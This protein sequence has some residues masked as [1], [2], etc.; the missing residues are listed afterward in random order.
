MKPVSKDHHQA[1]LDS[2]EQSHQEHLER[3]AHQHHVN[4]DQAYFEST[5]V[6]EEQKAAEVEAELAKRRK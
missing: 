2:Y 5:R 3:M 1:M 4:A 6:D